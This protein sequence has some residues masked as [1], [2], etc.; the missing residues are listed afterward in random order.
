M[1]NFVEGESLESVKENDFLKFPAAFHN[2]ILK[3]VM[4]LLL[5]LF[6]LLFEMKMN[7]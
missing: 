5:L 6:F 1:K 7:E 3:L 4:L 2:K